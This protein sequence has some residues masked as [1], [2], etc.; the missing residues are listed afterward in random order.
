MSGVDSILMATN[1]T[2]VGPLIHLDYLLQR[3]TCSNDQDSTTWSYRELITKSKATWKRTWPLSLD[4]GSIGNKVIR[5][6][7]HV[8]WCRVR[9]IINYQL[10]FKNVFVISYDILH[11]CGPDPAVC[12]QFDFLRLPGNR[13]SCVDFGDPPEEINENNVRERALL[14]LDQYRKKSKSFR[15]N[16]LLVP[17]GDDFR[18]DTLKEWENQYTNYQKIFEFINRSKQNFL[19]KFNMD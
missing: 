16:V 15:S 9:G 6:T 7:C 12:C 10:N 2:T 11:T 19:W 13:A 18:W 5:L 4:G 3:P 17:L 14:L 8:I 1:Q